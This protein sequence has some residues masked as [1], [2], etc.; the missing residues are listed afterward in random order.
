MKYVPSLP[1]PVSGVE[2]RRE[3]QALAAVKPSK[4]VQP[5]TLPP[6]LIQPHGVHQENVAGLQRET[7]AKQAEKRR[8][9][10]QESRRKYCRR[11]SHQTMLE[12]LR[13][14]LERRHHRQRENDTAE[15]IDEQV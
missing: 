2:D 1:P 13:S 14:G 3:V 10:I 15:H 8:E 7:A 4:R 9:P 5:R 12:E 11:V 6:L